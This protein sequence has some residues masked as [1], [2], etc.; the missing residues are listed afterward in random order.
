MERTRP[1]AIPFKKTNSA[2]P[3][4][5]ISATPDRRCK[6]CACFIEIPNPHNPAQFQSLCRRNGPQLM[7]TT[8]VGIGGPRQEVGLSF[9]LTQGDLVCFDGWREI[10]TAPGNR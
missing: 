8:V 5:G 9:A 7:M 4:F 3:D 2:A 6:N 1:T 10:Q